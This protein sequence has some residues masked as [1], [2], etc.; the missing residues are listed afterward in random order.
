MR[1]LIDEDVHIKVLGWLVAEGH[2][3]VRVPLG[4]KNGKVLELATQESR[5]LITRDKDFSDDT[6]RN[7][8]ITK[9]SLKIY[10]TP[11][12]RTGGRAPR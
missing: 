7:R 10:A 9:C 5:I 8:I 1:A 12:H 6:W 2:D 11:Y 4:F 3:A